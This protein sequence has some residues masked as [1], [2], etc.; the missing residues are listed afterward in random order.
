MQ[1]RQMGP[2]LDQ[3]QEALDGAQQ[4]VDLFFRNDDVGWGEDRL[5]EL[6]DIFDDL[7]LPV[8]LAVIPMELT[9]ARARDLLVRAAR[10]PQP[11]RFHQHGFAHVNHEPDG[12][13]YE[14]G[15]SRSRW[16]QAQDI[17]AGQ[18]RLRDLLGPS[19]DRIFTPPWNRCTDITGQCLAELGFEVLS[20]EGRAAPL[21]IPG[22]AELP[23]R[24][25]WFAH[26][27]GVRLTPTELGALMATA[28]RSGDPV[29]VMFHHAVMDAAERAAARELLALIAQ[30]PMA[31]TSSMA[32]L[33]GVTHV[34]AEQ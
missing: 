18:R 12:R 21:A 28:I 11:I 20:R 2:C 26:H 6:L 33:A 32:V 1:I 9:E 29:G 13:K 27:K 23:I 15:P 8:D 16:Q 14:F 5:D 30:H 4:P 10:S 17:A 25:D 34:E 31:A 24:V 7:G 3:V 19:V 22:L